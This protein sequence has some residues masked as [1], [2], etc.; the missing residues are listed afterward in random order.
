MKFLIPFLTCMCLATATA[1][2]DATYVID[3]IQGVKTKFRVSVLVLTYP[4]ESNPSSE[5]L[6]Y[7]TKQAS[8]K[9]NSKHTVAIPD[10]TVPIVIPK[11]RF[12]E[13]KKLIGSNCLLLDPSIECQ[14]IDCKGR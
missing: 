13:V 3:Y 12:D 8:E 1:F 11:N 5:D 14:T 10:S 4:S 7:A 2:C 9:W 6:S